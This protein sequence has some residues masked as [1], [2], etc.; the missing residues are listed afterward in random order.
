MVRLCRLL[1]GWRHTNNLLYSVRH[2]I[3]AS[4]L[5]TPPTPK[6]KRRGNPDVYRE[7]MARYMREWR[8]RQ[9][10]KQ[11]ES[12]DEEVKGKASTEEVLK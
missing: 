9:K 5:D 8:A 2:A 4:V 11:P 3:I 12:K 10:I 1:S 7:Y 6:K